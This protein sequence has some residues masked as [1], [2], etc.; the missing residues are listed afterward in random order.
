MKDFIAWI[1]RKLGLSKKYKDTI[2]VKEQPEETPRPPETP[3][4]PESPP[5]NIRVKDMV[6]D[7]SPVA[8]DWS[9]LW[10]NCILDNNQ[11][12]NN[13]LN[14]AVKKFVDNREKY[15]AVSSATG[16]PDWFIAGLHMRESS[17]SFTGC[18]HNGDP[19]NKV[20]KNVPKGRGPWKS[21]DEAAIDALA[22]DKITAEKT[23][24][25]EKCLEYAFRFNGVGYKKKIGDKGV[26]EYSPYVV[27]Y[28]EWHD[29]TSKYKSDGVYDK[30]AKEEQ[31]GVMA[32]WKKLE[33]LGLITIK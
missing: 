21:W 33:N 22:Y 18:L 17:F 15:Q 4:T 3:V 31:L 12:A 2:P 30:N 10:D 14:S 27:A 19:W 6:N 23:N 8:P 24:T 5:T 13:L 25:I 20:T 16:V 1:K 32:F 29:E 28:T 26:I 7:G 9:Y 11:K